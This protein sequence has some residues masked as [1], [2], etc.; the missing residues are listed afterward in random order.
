MKD[1][2]DKL[3]KA[4]TPEELKKKK[5]SEE[6]EVEAED[7]P[8]QI[9]FKKKFKRT[10]KKDANAAARAALKGPQEGAPTNG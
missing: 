1:L 2:L 3:S 7:A 10:G 5:D 8:Q 9:K 6:T 4:M